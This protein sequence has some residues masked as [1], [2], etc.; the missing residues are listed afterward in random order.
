MGRGVWTWGQ[1]DYKYPTSLNFDYPSS[2]DN[3]T[4]VIGAVH[5]SNGVLYFSWKNGSTY[6]IDIVNTAKYRATGELH[7]IVHY[8]KEA[9]EKKGAMGI[10]AGFQILAAGEKIEVFL[11]KDL[12]SFSAS[13]ALSIDYAYTPD[14]GDTYPDRSVLNKREDVAMDAADYT[15]LETKVVLTAGTS[16][17]TTPE[18][19]E[20]SVLFDPDVEV[21]Q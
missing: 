18:L 4:D 7:S 2:N 14:S 6:G 8:G 5:S 10:K 17:L 16:Q 13:T 1:W 20:L 15:F 3:T 9:D 11:K 19:I 21:A 12:E